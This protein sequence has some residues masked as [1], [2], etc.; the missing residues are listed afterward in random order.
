MAK[1]YKE[2]E[3]EV[4]KKYEPECSVGLCVVW[5]CRGPS[6]L[7]LPVQDLYLGTSHV[8]PGTSCVE[9]SLRPSTVKR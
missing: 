3:K 7:D 4:K 8:D 9:T 2:E 6:K 1:G 5:R